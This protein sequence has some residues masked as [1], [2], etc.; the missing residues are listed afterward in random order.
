ML[1]NE[2]R[3]QF[4][5][6]FN[7]NTCNPDSTVSNL[8]S[9]KAGITLVALV[10]TIIVLLILAGITLGFVVGKNGIINMAQM[11]GKNY[12]GAKEE[13]S[14]GLENLYSSIIIATNDDSKITISKED[15]QKIIDDRVSQKNTSAT[16]ILYPNGSEENPPSIASNQ[17]IEIDNPYPGH[18]L[19]VRVEIYYK[20]MWGDPGFI[21]AQNMGGY[22]VKVNQYVGNGKD[23][24]VIQSGEKAISTNSSSIGN[25]FEDYTQ[26]NPTQAPY[27]LIVVC[28][29]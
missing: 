5:A 7:R 16:Q 1:K 11:A 3:E 23:K 27:R 17:R 14:K 8:H 24:I 13:E 10:I 19:Y 9:N 4:K 6:M 15:L 21:Y 25:P 2:K 22:G 26:T 20:E 29:D 12:T 18:K 28:L